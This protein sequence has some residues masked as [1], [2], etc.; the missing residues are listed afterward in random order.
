M[1]ELDGGPSGESSQGGLEAGSMVHSDVQLTAIMTV[2]QGLLD[3]AQ[4]TSWPANN[5]RGGLW[6]DNTAGKG[7]S[8]RD[9]TL[10]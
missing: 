3:K 9:K 6:Q 7:G 2:V 1:G 4:S 8:S 10:K 5:N